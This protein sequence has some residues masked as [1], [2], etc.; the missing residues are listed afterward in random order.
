M[1][2]DELIQKAIIQ[3]LFTCTG[4][5]NLLASSNE[6]RE[7]QYQNTSF[8]Y[9]AIRVAINDQSPLGNAVGRTKLSLVLFSIIVFTENP[10][11]KLCNQIGG[12]VVDALFDSQIK[13]SDEN[14]IPE[15]FKLIRIDN[16]ASTAAL[17]LEDR[18]WQKELFF[19]SE[20]HKLR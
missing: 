8:A 13:G 16:L 10:S 1:I 19:Q 15:Y 9:P 12:E 7:D 4:V 3:K 14:N 5:V 20:A 6:I 11:S 2:H 18:L 17:R